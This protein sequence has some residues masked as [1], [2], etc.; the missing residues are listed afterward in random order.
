MYFFF[1]V[2]GPVTKGANKCGCLYE[3]VYGIR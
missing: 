1:N 2:D 3:A